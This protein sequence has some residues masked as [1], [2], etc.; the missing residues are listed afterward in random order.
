[1]SEAKKCDHCGD[2]FEPIPN[3]HLHDY[4]NVAIRYNTSIWSKPD[5]FAKIGLYARSGSPQLI[6]DCKSCVIL[7]V[8]RF[9]AKFDIKEQKGGTRFRFNPS[10]D[11]K[12][13][14]LNSVV[15]GEPQRMREFFEPYLGQEIKVTVEVL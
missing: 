5:I 9:M 3:I 13:I 1:M 14:K 8:R 15:E 10:R 2:L 11:S 12:G 4:H 7:A 6:D